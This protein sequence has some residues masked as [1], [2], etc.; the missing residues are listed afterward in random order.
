MKS[1]QQ[2]VASV[3]LRA[4]NQRNMTSQV[5]YADVM[6]DDLSPSLT[7]EADFAIMWWLCYLFVFKK[8]NHDCVMRRCFKMPNA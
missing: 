2:G 3:Q 8:K 4:V 7:G 6:L 5:V 1:G